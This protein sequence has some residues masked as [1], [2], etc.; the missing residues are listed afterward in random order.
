MKPAVPQKN[1]RS[2][3]K[4]PFTVLAGGFMFLLTSQLIA[5]A[6]LQFVP[7]SL[8]SAVRL[9]LL[10]LIT[11]VILATLLQIVIRFTPYSWA[12]LGIRAPK[13]RWF[14]LFLSSTVLYVLLSAILM[15]L[16][17]LIFTGFNAS[18]MQEVGL[19]KPSS[20]IDLTLGFIS[21]VILTPIIEEVIFRGIFFRG[22]KATIPA[23]AAVVISSALF[24]VA[25]GQWNVALDT[26]AL[27]VFLAYLTYKTGSLLPAILLHALKN[28]LAYILLFVF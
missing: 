25:H 19:S 4:Q 27:G 1:H 15:T 13:G 17:S 24:A 9:A 23:W 16:A 2:L 26:F 8:N 11:F 21:L 6:I 3:L 7:V 12:S 18:E 20:R 10:L 22:L 28:G 14:R 5:S